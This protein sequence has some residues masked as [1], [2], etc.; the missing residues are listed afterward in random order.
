MHGLIIKKKWL[1]LIISGKK[2]LEIRGSNTK[3]IGEPI[4]L[5]ESGTHRVRGICKIKGTHLMTRNN[6]D[7]EK[8]K[9]CVDISFL[10]LNKIYLTAYAWELTDIE[11]FE[12]VSYYSHPK[13][14]VIWVK[15]VEPTDEMRDSE[16]LRYGY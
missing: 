15:D 14:A 12:D 11:V 1:D 10:E 9:H 4:Y 3:K 16:Y 8:D 7:K 2:T 6:W 13:G 5:L